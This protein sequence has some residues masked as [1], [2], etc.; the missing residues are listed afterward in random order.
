[1]MRYKLPDILYK[2][3]KVANFIVTD[4]REFA[5]SDD[6]FYEFYHRATL[7]F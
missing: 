6:K 4:V 5:A 3:I 1:M 7:R 2:V